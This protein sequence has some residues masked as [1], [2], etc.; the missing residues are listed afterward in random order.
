MLVPLN[1]HCKIF[2]MS[3]IIKGFGC[4]ERKLFFNNK[5]SYLSQPVYHIEREEV[6]NSSVHVLNIYDNNNSTCEEPRSKTLDEDINLAETYKRQQEDNLKSCLN[7]YK[8][9]ITDTNKVNGE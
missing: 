1:D 7:R 5:S 2:Q 4:I 6:S 3:L 9:I 8:Y